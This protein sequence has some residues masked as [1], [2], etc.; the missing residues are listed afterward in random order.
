MYHPAPSSLVSPPCRSATVHPAPQCGT[1]KEQHLQAEIK[2]VVSS[3]QPPQKI[4]SQQLAHRPSLSLSLSLACS[5]TPRLPPP[6][7]NHN[8]SPKRQSHPRQVYNLQQQQ[9]QQRHPLTPN[10]YPLSSHTVP[11]SGPAHINRHLL[12]VASP[13]IHAHTPSLPFPSPRAVF[14]V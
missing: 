14:V 9:Q 4:I 2:C 5:Q 13:H 12:S 8:R 3:S 10:N 11:G 6:P 7:H 1:K